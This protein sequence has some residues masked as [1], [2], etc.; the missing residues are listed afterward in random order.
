MDFSSRLDEPEIHRLIKESTGCSI[1]H[2]MARYR[3]RRWRLF[4]CEEGG[5]VL[6][7]IGIELRRSDARVV[8]HSFTVDSGHRRRGVGRRIIREVAATF[9]GATIEAETDTDAVGFYTRCGFAVE[10]LGEKY[11]DTER[12]AARFAPPRS[13]SRPA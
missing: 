12:F 13:R 8:I 7:C 4:G 5:T 10:S 2:A 1:E 6:G 9:P 11:P 3:S